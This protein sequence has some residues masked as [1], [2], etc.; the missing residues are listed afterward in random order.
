MAKATSEDAP[1]RTPFSFLIE[2]VSLVGSGAKKEEEEK[3]E[4]N[5]TKPSVREERPV[6][7]PVTETVRRT[8]H[9]P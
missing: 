2:A 8:L 1:P 6:G 3:K 9:P 5:S 4:A 7:T